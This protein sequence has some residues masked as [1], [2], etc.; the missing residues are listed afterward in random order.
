MHPALRQYVGRPPRFA[1]YVALGALTGFAGVALAVSIVHLVEVRRGNERQDRIERRHEARAAFASNAR[2]LV[3]ARTLARDYAVHA[4]PSWTAANP[5]RDCPARLAELEP[6][7][8]DGTTVDPW[9]H[10][11]RFTCTG[12]RIS[13]SSDG[14]DRVR[15]TRDDIR[16]TR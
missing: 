7:V 14:P 10:P 11:F 13:V 4:W 2:D 12:T 15:N 5:D 9:G 1:R 6:Y 3:L 8:G 16:S